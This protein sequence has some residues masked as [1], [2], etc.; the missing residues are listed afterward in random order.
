MTH[1]RVASMPAS[2]DLGPH[3][4]SAA[5]LL[6]TLPWAAIGWAIYG[7][8]EISVLFFYLPMSGQGVA[9]WQG[10]VRWT[11]GPTLLWVLFTPAIVGLSRRFRVLGPRAGRAALVHVGAA[12]AAHVL[13]AALV[14]ALYPVI[15]HE[16]RPRIPIMLMQGL[17]LDL[18]RYAIVAVGIHAADYYR[19]YRDRDLE[20]LRLRSQLDS[21]RLEVL[22]VQL[23]PHFLFN[24]LHAISELTYRDPQ[25]AD[26]ALTR[27]ADLLR[28]TLANADRQEATLAEER[29]FLET[30]LEIERMRLGGALEVHL[31]VAD[32]TL[33]LLVPSLLLQPLAENA[34]RHGIRGN[35]GGLLRVTARR[36]D[37]R[38][39]IEVADDGR[40]LPTSAIREGLG[41]GSTR[42]RLQALYGDAHELVLRTRPEG[43]TVVSVTLPAREAAA[44]TPAAADAPATEESRC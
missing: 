11:L 41:L 37:G 1:T 39:H 2:S 20:A 10:L 24:T 38:L 25:L 34:L 18:L 5:A 3:D 15:R 21:A 35:P 28:M 32:D 23:Q 26:R 33:G 14:Y 27:L 19:L 4:S 31:D 29:A 17:L 7:L 12:L 9:S 40:G 13:T 6:K 22:K 42:V 8:L 30:Y 36:R 43:G 16:A 44:A